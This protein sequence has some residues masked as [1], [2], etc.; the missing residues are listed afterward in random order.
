MFL[1]VR[2]YSK[3]SINSTE[4]EPHCPLILSK[5]AFSEGSSWWKFTLVFSICFNSYL[6]ASIQANIEFT[7]ILT[8]CSFET[9]ALF[10]LQMATKFRP[11]L[12]CSFLVTGW[13]LLVPWKIWWNRTW[14]CFW[15]SLAESQPNYLKQSMTVTL[16]NLVLNWTKNLLHSLFPLLF[17]GITSIWCTDAL[18]WRISSHK[19]RNW[20]KLYLT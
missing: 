10:V 16:L 7:S 19:S 9:R 2:I 11:N 20:R 4:N 14:E 8:L 17:L 3:C 12:S 18:L 5:A 15:S 1:Y 6:F 13:R